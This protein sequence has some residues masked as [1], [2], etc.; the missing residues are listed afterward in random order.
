MDFS[1]K[2]TPNIKF[3]PKWEVIHPDDEKYSHLAKY[4]AIPHT[5]KRESDSDNNIKESTRNIW[6]D[7]SDYD[8]EEEKKMISVK[9][10]ST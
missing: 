6:K 4:K 2:F 5:Y 8:E 7:T 3:N 1:K 10:I 9:F